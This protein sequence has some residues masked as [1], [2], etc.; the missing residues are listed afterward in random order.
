MTKILFFFSNELNYT[1]GIRIKALGC[2]FNPSAFGFYSCKPVYRGWQAD[3]SKGD[4]VASPPLYIQFPGGG[5]IRIKPDWHFNP[6][7]Y[8]HPLLQGGQ[9]CSSYFYIYNSLRGKD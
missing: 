2:V 8:G 5:R 6:P 4:K 7:P 3:F 9:V 1:Q